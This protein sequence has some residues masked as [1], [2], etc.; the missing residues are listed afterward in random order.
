MRSVPPGG[1][2]SLG[3]ARQRSR[4]LVLAAALLLG[5]GCGSSPH[6]ATSATTTRGEDA[7]KREEAVRRRKER[8]LDERVSVDNVQRRL[9][10][11]LDSI[12]AGLG[13]GAQPSGVVSLSA[14]GDVIYERSFGYAD[15]ARE[16]RNEEDTA[17]RIGAIT[18]QFTAAA[19]LRLV[20]AGKLAT[21]DPISKFLPDYPG[22][23]GAISVHQLLSHTSGLPNYSNRPELLARRGAAITPRELLELF[24]AEPLEFEPGR[25][26]GYSDSDYVVLGLI[27]EKV[28]RQSYAEH[29]R[30][31]LFEP[32]DLDDTQVGAPESSEDAARGYSAAPDGGLVPTVGFDDSLLYAAAGVRSTAQDLQRWHDALQEG[33]V[34]EPEL[35]E[36]SL[37]VVENHYAYGWFVR[38]QRGFQ[39]LSHPGAVEGF[40]SH[41]ARVP[42]LDLSIVVLMNN[43]SV[44]ATS[45][46]DAALGIAL[47]EAIEP[48]PRQ[49]SVALDP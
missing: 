21:S 40:V 30:E 48:L 38:E 13:P 47:G 43:S 24:W 33:D 36:R 17:F 27:I 7:A 11:Y 26:F 15:L 1:Y 23:G 18:A 37:L 42:E 31:A 49:S 20:Q 12:G 25:D 14:G 41:F 28:T 45:I 2:L 22:P 10:P 8:R 35:E 19:V 46:A 9:S 6:A 32:F 44:D 39:V 16:E 5:N 34:L 3:T 4:A 29:M